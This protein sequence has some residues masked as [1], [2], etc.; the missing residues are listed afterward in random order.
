MKKVIMLCYL[1]ALATT[2][3]FTQCRGFNK[4][5]KIIPGKPITG[6]LSIKKYF[7]LFDQ[8]Q[9]L[10]NSSIRNLQELAEISKYEGKLPNDVPEVI[11]ELNYKDIVRKYHKV[12][13]IEGI[14]TWDCYDIRTGL[15]GLWT[16]DNYQDEYGIEMWGMVHKS[17]A[18]GNSCFDHTNRYKKILLERKSLSLGANNR[19]SSLSDTTIVQTPGTHTQSYRVDSFTFHVKNVPKIEFIDGGI[20]HKQL[21]D[22][23]VSGQKTIVSDTIEKHIYLFNHYHYTAANNHQGATPND[24]VINNYDERRD[25]SQRR[26]SYPPVRKKRIQTGYVCVAEKRCCVSGS[27]IDNRRTGFVYVPDN[28]CTCKGAGTIN[29]K[30]QTKVEAND[31]VYGE[32][33]SPEPYSSMKKTTKTTDDSLE[34]EKY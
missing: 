33:Q 16:R 18:C 6:S 1:S 17:F 34:R 27:S 22:Q 13:K 9:S 12:I 23:I 20:I 14:H 24:N 4:D 31:D 2:S 21:P 7:E 26:V 15:Y 3:V 28:N 5:L 30:K 29:T 32:Y 8:S 10:R 25:F 11:T 19:S